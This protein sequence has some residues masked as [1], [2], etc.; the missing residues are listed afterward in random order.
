MFVMNIG[1]GGH[2]KH[3]SEVVGR[4]PQRCMVLEIRGV[5]SFGH[6]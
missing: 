5:H 1:I 2:Y 3:Y 6:A 4:H